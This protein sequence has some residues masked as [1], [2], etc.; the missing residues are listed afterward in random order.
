[1]AAAGV[2]VKVIL[3]K[4]DPEQIAVTLRLAV[5]GITP[6]VAHPGAERESVPLTVTLPRADRSRLAALADLRLISA[7]GTTVPL[8]MKPTCLPSLNTLSPGRVTPRPASSTSRIPSSTD[9]WPVLR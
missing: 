6:A 8:V 4:V 5:S 7:T 3:T 1:M 2:T 9:T